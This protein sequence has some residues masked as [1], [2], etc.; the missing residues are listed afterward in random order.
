VQKPATN[1]IEQI[2]LLKQ[3][4]LVGADVVVGSDE[5]RQLMRW[6]MNNSYY[7]LS[8]YW[9]YHQK[10]PHAGE[11]WFVSGSVAEVQAA[12]DFDTNL[13][14]YLSEGLAVIEVTFRS[15]LAYFVATELAPD[16]Y[17]NPATYIDR[18]HGSS[19]VRL[20]DQ[21]LDDIARD[22]ERSKERFI[23]H[24]VDAGETVPMWAA[25]EA[26]SFGTVSKIYALLADTGIRTKVS[27]SF[28]VSSYSLMRSV[29][30]SLV[31]LRNTCAHH[32][33]VWN[34]IPDIACPVL[35]PLKVESAGVYQQ[36]PW[37]WVVMVRH[38]VD[39]IRGDQQF[40]ADLTGFL[41][42][43]TDMLDGL[44]YPRNH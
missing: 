35:N 17:L 3:R 13:R 10:H 42:R 24:H 31:T 44:K 32:G 40:S 1:I 38:L 37:G 28:E 33:R 27:K 12:Y 7:R 6:L 23:A 36:T 20:R 15:R 11:N 29:I 14:S 41:D 16:A 34:R 8:G 39:R 19:G 43:N 25:V 5:H 30:R 9:R 2:D 26:M 21:L 18:V 22:L 4:G